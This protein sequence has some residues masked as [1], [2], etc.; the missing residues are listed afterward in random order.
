MNRYP[1]YR[2][3][4]PVDSVMPAG[5]AHPAPVQ[6]APLFHFPFPSPANESEERAIF[7]WINSHLLFFLSL[8]IATF[9]AR[10]A[11]QA[12]QKREVASLALWLDRLTTLRLA[13]VSFTCSAANLTQEVYETYIRPSMRSMRADFSG[14]SSPDN[15][16]YSTALAEMKEAVSELLLTLPPTHALPIQQALAAYGQADGVWWSHHGQIMR[17]LIS[18][19]HSLARLEYERQASVQGREIRYEEF[20]QQTLRT[21]EALSENDLFFAVRRGSVSLEQFRHHLRTMLTMMHPYQ[22]PVDK[23]VGFWE[24]GAEL[25]GKIIDEHQQAP[26][27]KRSMRSSVRRTERT[28]I[29]ALC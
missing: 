8:N 6:D 2:L 9:A 23:L 27:G 29:K 12:A 14:V 21:T 11:H 18:T 28:P 4:L 19:P 22:E 16:V 13:S 1:V 20:K 26:T 24:A 25:M 10:Q 17:R 3:T 15:G 5:T 7:V